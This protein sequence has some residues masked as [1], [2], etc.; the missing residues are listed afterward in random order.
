MERVDGRE[1]EWEMHQRGNMGIESVE[2]YL[3]SVAKTRGFLSRAVV[4]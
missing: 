4:I 2:T 3:L 1:E